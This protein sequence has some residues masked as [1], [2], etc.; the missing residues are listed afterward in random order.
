M[1]RAKASILYD[2]LYDKVCARFDTTPTARGLWREETINLLTKLNPVTDLQPQ[3]APVCDANSIVPLDIQPQRTPCEGVK[4]NGGVVCDMTA[5]PC[6]CGAWRGLPPTELCYPTTNEVRFTV[7]E[8]YETE[9]DPAP[10]MLPNGNLKETAE[11]VNYA[12]PE[13]RG[14]E[15]QPPPLPAVC[16]GPPQSYH[17]QDVNQEKKI[18]YLDFL[19]TWRTEDGSIVE[20]CARDKDGSWLGAFTYKNR[21][22]DGTWDAYGNYV[23]HLGA[24]LNNWDLLDKVRDN[25]RVNLKEYKA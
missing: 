14:S 17:N 19:G 24:R 25:E 8:Y 12:P 22:I 10:S 23:A 6:V 9:R 7:Q 21:R 18:D 13:E 2:E 11:E 16:T 4:K 5:G 1:T 3:A 20:I 15:E